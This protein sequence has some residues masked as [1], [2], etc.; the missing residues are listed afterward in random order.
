MEKPAETL[1]PRQTRFLESLLISRSHLLAAIENLS[2]QT[3]IHAFVYSDWTVKDIFGHLVSWDDEFRLD[4]RL[5]LQ[6]QHP[7]Y[8]R[9]ISG[10]LDFT[11]LIRS[12]TPK[13]FRQRGVTPWKK[14]ARDKPGVLTAKDTESVETLVSYH[15]RHW[16]QHADWLER[17]QN[18]T[19]KKI[20]P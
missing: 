17:W 4:I 9:L 15:W 2:E 10:D 16:N 13:E 20:Y 12:L 1:T 3:I 18:K 5:I 11:D 19:D 8:S 6:G 7:G 14:A